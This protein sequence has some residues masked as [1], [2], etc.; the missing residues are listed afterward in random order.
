MQCLLG[1][2]GPVRDCH[3]LH[4][5]LRISATTMVCS[6]A[7]ILSSVDGACRDD[8]AVTVVQDPCIPLVKETFL[9]IA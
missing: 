6:H 9:R 4:Q 2:V 3:L 5:I 7:V 1:Q 8:R